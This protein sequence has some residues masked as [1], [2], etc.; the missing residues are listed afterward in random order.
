MPPTQLSTH[1]YNGIDWPN[2]SLLRDTAFGSRF[3]LFISAPLL[4]LALYIPAWLKRQNRIVGNRE[5]WC[6]VAFTLLSFLFCSANQFGRL[7]FNSG[8]RHIV[9]VV[10]LLFL[11][12]AG[13]LLRLRP[14]LAV[15][16]GI[17]TT[18]WSWCLAMYRDVEQGLGVFESLK[19][20]SVNG[21]R[22]PW[23]TTL[24]KMG[25]L[26]EGASALPV[27]LLFTAI[28]WRLWKIDFKVSR[29]TQSQ[30]QS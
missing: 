1:G 22:L 4:L 10:P 29:P 7:Q 9:P 5:T 13:V 8:V 15:L 26:S 24:Q 2:L 25:Y 17:V 14:L 23:M 27:L 18:Y 20:I 3:G 19:Q 21:L 6:V 11:L 28:I 12:V 16:V 30:T